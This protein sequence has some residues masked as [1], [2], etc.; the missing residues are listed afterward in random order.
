MQE[1]VATKIKC[2]WCKR[3]IWIPSPCLNS[4]VKDRFYCSYCGQYTKIKEK[5]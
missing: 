1:K 4:D 3:E 2:Q 5:E